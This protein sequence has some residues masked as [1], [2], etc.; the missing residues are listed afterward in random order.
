MRVD[1]YPPNPK[2][3]KGKPA[4][5]DACLLARLEEPYLADSGIKFSDVGVTRSA[6]NINNNNNIVTRNLAFVNLGRACASCRTAAGGLSGSDMHRVYI[7]NAES[8]DQVFKVDMITQKDVEK[9]LAGDISKYIYITLNLGDLYDRWQ[10]AGGHGN[11]AAINPETKTVT[12]D[13]ATPLRLEGINLHAGE[14]FPVDLTFTLRSGVTVPFDVKDFNIY[15]RQLIHEGKKD[16]I[17]GVVVYNVNIAATSQGQSRGTQNT[18]A[19]IALPEAL[20]PYYSAFPNPVSG[21]LSI[22]YSGSIKTQAD[23]TLTD[24]SGKLI[25]RKSGIMLQPGGTYQMKMGSLPAGIYIL[26]TE[27][28]SGNSDTRKITKE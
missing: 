3:L 6:T 7:A 14:H 17:Y 26:R 16:D 8:H 15:I 21:T 12:Y 25:A 2:V 22:R 13:P 19:G 5:L 4:R 11:Y 23:F 27:D 9:H 10:E 1:W 24:V 28:T 18:N 20:S